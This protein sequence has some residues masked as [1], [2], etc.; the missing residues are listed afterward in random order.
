MAERPLNCRG[1]SQLP[2][3][4]QLMAALGLEAGGHQLFA[5]LPT[6]EGI[7][8]TLTGFSEQQS[9]AADF[10]GAVAKV[11]GLGVSILLIAYSANWRKFISC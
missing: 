10:H 7:C 11:I 6:L 9:V 5:E 8:S 1:R 3:I 4:K 2:F